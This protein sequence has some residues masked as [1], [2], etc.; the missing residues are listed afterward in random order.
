MQDRAPGHR[1]G[2]TL[3]KLAGRG[4]YPIEWPPFSLDLNPIEKVWNLIKNY[5]QENFSEK[6]SYDKLREAVKEAWEKVS[7]FDL[8]E[9]IEQM[10]E[11][12]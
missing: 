10:Q 7:D 11:R 12:Y 9:L 8:N 2:I 1:A 6:M 5:I 3:V 4:I